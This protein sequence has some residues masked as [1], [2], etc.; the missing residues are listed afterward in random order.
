[1]HLGKCFKR[2][3]DFLFHCSLDVHV[4]DLGGGGDALLPE[5]G[6][7][8]FVLAGQSLCRQLNPKVVHACAVHHDGRAAVL[9]LVRLTFFIELGFDGPRVFRGETGVE[10]CHLR[11]E[12]PSHQEDG[13]E[14]HTHHS[15]AQDDLLFEGEAFQH[16]AGFARDCLWEGLGHQTGIRMISLKA[17][18]ARLRS[19][20]V[21]STAS[22]A[23]VAAIV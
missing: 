18:I 22:C 19:T 2:F 7:P 21:R 14:N 13:A 20:T 23:L 17:W 4:L 10:G 16:G 12:R 6:I 8:P 1:M 9:D 5:Q 15:Q 3:R 11:G